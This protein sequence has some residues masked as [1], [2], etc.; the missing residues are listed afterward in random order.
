[1]GTYAYL[2]GWVDGKVT[3][4]QVALM[5]ASLAADD[6]GR[7]EVD[8]NGGL[9]FSGDCG[10]S[11]Y[12]GAQEAIQRM[13]TLAKV[14]GEYVLKMDESSETEVFFFGGDLYRKMMGYARLRGLVEDATRT[15]QGY[16]QGITDEDRAQWAIERGGVK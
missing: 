8:V 4:E 7:I 12:D 16:S 1:M 6:M 10:Y 14:E 13:A 11:F 15:Y 3:P 9:Y 5:K 2:D